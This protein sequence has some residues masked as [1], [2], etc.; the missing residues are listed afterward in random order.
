MG[1]TNPLISLPVMASRMFANVN[2]FKSS[3]FC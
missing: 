1:R 2:M 3:L